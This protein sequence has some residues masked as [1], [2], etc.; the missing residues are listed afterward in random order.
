MIEAI[1]SL[2]TK[3]ITAP[4][5]IEDTVALCRGTEV[6]IELD[7]MMLAGTSPLLFAS[8]LERFLGLYCSINSFTR[9][10]TTLSGKDGEL[11]RWPPRAGEK[12]LV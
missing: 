12:A 5:Q 3:P 11:K 4:I 7:P 6:H 2:V 9:L 1:Q 8:V 10:I